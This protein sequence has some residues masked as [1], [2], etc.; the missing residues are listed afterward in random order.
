MAKSARAKQLAMEKLW[1]ESGP[2]DEGG[3]AD[4]EAEEEEANDFS[5]DE[6]VEVLQAWDRA[7]YNIDITAMLFKLI[8]SPVNLG[9]FG[10]DVHFQL[11]A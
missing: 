2:M 3:V 10:V 9:I 5:D 1:M 11:F 7:R 6:E 8:W 4:Q